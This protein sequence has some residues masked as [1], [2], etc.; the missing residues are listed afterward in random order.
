MFFGCLDNRVEG[1]GVIFFS[2]F[3]F[4][5]CENLVEV[6]LCEDVVMWGYFW[7]FVVLRE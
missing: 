7:E 3:L 1:L 2:M 6:F 4:G 5:D